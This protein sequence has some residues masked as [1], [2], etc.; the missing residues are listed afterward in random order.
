MRASR[1]VLS[2]GQELSIFSLPLPQVSRPQAYVSLAHAQD[3]LQHFLLISLSRQK[4]VLVFP[5]SWYREQDPASDRGQSPGLYI[6][7]FCRRNLSHSA[8]SL[9]HRALQI[10]RYHEQVLH[11]AISQAR[12]DFRWLQRERRS[13]PATARVTS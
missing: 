1:T 3:F 7:L 11:Q 12:Q 8:S 4:Q 10:S 6:P 5:P 9:L 2:H 13:V